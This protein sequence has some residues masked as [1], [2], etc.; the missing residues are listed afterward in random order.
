MLNMTTTNKV[1]KQDCNTK[2]ILEHMRQYVQFERKLPTEMEKRIIETYLGHPF[3]L[4][5]I[6]LED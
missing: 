4:I 2:L 6:N 3:A 1:Q 5:N